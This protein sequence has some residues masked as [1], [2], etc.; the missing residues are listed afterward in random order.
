VVLAAD[1]SVDR[2]ATESRRRELSGQRGETQIFVRGP[3]LDELRA[4]CLDET[5]LPAPRPPVF[6][7]AG[8]QA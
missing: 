4:R 8:A 5:G 1:G 6:R 3:D 7:T 2:D